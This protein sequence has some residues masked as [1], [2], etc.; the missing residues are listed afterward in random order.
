MSIEKN[1][2]VKATGRELTKAYHREKIL[3]ATI[4]V[5][6]QY[7]IVGTTISRVVKKAGLSR[8]M[9]NLHF[10]SKDNLLLEVIKF[11]LCEYAATWHK[12]IETAGDSPADKI[13]SMIFADFNPNIFNSETVAVWFAY[14][15]QARAQ[16]KY[17][18][19]VS[20]REDDSLR[21]FTVLFEQLIEES[22]CYHNDA[23]CIARGL[24]AME[25]GMWLD[26]F[27]YPNHF[28]THKALRS[29]FDF[30]AAIFPDQFD[31]RHSNEAVDIYD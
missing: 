23:A 21:S 12:A 9:V 2:I 15:E 16:P 10:K 24:V 29:I 6:A 18:P 28:D 11:L 4:S 27:L 30:L 19:Y 13:K 8:G 20:T 5:V 31:V 7:G 25:E 1:C 3:N 22:G 26:Y 17:L 14:R